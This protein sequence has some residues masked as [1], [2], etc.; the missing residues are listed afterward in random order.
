MKMR[1][2][3][4]SPNRRFASKWTRGIAKHGYTA[5]PNI[6]LLSRRELDI[7][8]A[9]AYLLIVIE[10]YRWSSR[11]PWPSVHTIAERAGVVERSARR[12]IKALEAKGL[13]QRTKRPGKTNTYSTDGLIVQLDIIANRNPQP[14]QKWHKSSDSY[15]PPGRTI[16]SGKEDELK[17]NG[18]IRGDYSKKGSSSAPQQ[19][20]DFMSKLNDFGK[21]A[22]N[23]G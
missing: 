22:I 12:H 15:V 3:P 6:L 8:V 16:L 23:D 20:G 10:S 18:L 2:A 9:Q 5:V 11:R 17:E 13:I 4:A 1:E 7:S 19:L 14:G 21:R